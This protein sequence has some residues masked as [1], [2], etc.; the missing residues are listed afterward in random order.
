VI[1]FDEHSRTIDV[2]LIP[3][4]PHA[5]GYTAGMLHDQLYLIGPN[6]GTVMPVFDFGSSQKSGWPQL[7]RMTEDGQRVWKRV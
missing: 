6:V 7:M 5:R 4:D 2:R 3:G 1:D